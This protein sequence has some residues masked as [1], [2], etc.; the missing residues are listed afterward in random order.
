MAYQIGLEEIRIKRRSTMN[1]PTAIKA[2]KYFIKYPDKSIGD[3]E[4]NSMRLG[5]EA[6]RRIKY[7][8]PSLPF[9]PY[10]KLPGE[11]HAMETIRS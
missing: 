9:V 4:L 8:R 5:I 2:L 11:T 10:D 3:D 1:I 6:L 7:S